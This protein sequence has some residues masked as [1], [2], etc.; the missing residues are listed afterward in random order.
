LLNQPARVNGQR[1]Y[2][3]NILEQLRAIQVAQQAGFTLSEIGT[4]FSGFSSDTPVSKRWREMANRKI[5]EVDGLIG[6]AQRMKQILESGLQCR[7]V[8][9]K[10]CLLI[11]TPDHPVQLQRKSARAK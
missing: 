5:V 10:D 8:E 3:S 7:C 9:L 6:K 4:L 11:L 2:D 1:R